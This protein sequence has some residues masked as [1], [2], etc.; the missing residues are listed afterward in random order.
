MLKLFLKDLLEVLSIILK[1]VMVGIIIIIGMFIIGMIGCSIVNIISGT[2]LFDF[3]FYT[4]KEVL[5]VLNAIEFGGF[6]SILMVMVGLFIFAIKKIVLEL[7]GYFL[8]LRHRSY[9]EKHKL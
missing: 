3:S 7:K 6:I 4:E 5:F 8:R 1:L 2:S 9:L